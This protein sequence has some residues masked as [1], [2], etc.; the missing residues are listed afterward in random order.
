MNPRPTSRV[1]S[2]LGRYSVRAAGRSAAESIDDG[3]GV[4]FEIGWG[5]IR[6]GWEVGVNADANR[7]A[8][9]EVVDVNIGNEQGGAA[10]EKIVTAGLAN[11][12]EGNGPVPLS[13]FECRGLAVASGWACGSGAV[14]L[15]PAPA[16]A[17]FPGL[18]D[19]AQDTLDG[20][21]EARL[22]CAGIPHLERGVD[23]L[24]GA[25]F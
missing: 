8:R 10:S 18:H 13:D 15:M 23:W 22:N 24:D 16:T 6:R 2:K 7:H 5:G 4:A 21:I 1:P 12:P 17:G 11:K 20:R 9:S 19:D 25:G 3:V 14:S